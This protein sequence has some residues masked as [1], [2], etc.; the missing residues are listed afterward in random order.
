MYNNNQL[1]EQLG[2]RLVVQYVISRKLVPRNPITVTPQPTPPLLLRLRQLRIS[3]LNIK[4]RRLPN[5]LP[6]KIPLLNNKIPIFT[7][8]LAVMPLH[9]LVKRKTVLGNVA[10]GAVAR[11]VE[12]F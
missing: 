8:F 7:D 2:Y 9:G 10:F 4:N 12:P 1:T 6:K 3:R 11:S 5:L